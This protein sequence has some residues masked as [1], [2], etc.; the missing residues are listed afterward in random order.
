ML[1]R[2]TLVVTEL[3]VSTMFS[4]NGT[5]LAIGGALCSSLAAILAYPYGNAFDRFF[6]GLYGVAP[7]IFSSIIQLIST[8]TAANVAL[9]YCCT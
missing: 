2:D 1:E 7:G 8:N 9:S 4:E 6:S 3:G 5:Q